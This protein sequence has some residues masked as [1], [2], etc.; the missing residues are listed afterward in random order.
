MRTVGDLIEILERFDRDTPVLVAHQPSWPLQETLQDCLS[1]KEVYDADYEYDEDTAE[2]S[3]D[4][5]F[6]EAVRARLGREADDICYI[7][8]GGQNAASPYAPREVFC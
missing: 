3:K 5:E 8:L 1:W 7:V 2:I 6:R 4:E